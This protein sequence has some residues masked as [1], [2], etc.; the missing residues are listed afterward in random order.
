MPFFPP[1][2]AK[3]AS[4]GHPDVPALLQRVIL[5]QTNPHHCTPFDATVPSVRAHEATQVGQS[6]HDFIYPPVICGNAPT[7]TSSRW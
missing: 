6:Q 7:S 3:G 4:T 2:A 5:E 1:L